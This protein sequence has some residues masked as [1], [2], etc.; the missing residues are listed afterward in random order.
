MTSSTKWTVAIFAVVAMFGAGMLWGGNVASELNP[1]NIL[2]SFDGLPEGDIGTATS[3]QLTLPEA[4]QGASGVP[5]PLPQAS[6]NN[7]LLNPGGGNV[8]I[9]TMDPKHLLHLKSDFSKLRIETNSD[10]AWTTIQLHRSRAGPPEVE[11]DDILGVVLARGSDGTKAQTAAVIVFLVDGGPGPGDM[12]GR[13]EFKTTLDGSIDTVTRMVIKNTGNVGIGTINPGHPLEMGSGA[14]VTA[15]GV[16]TDASSRL[17]KENIRDLT[18]EEA[19]AALRELTPTRFNY[20]VDKEEEHVGFIAEDV[21]ELVANK[22]RNGL[23]PMDI[24]AV[25]TKVVQGQEKKLAQL[26]AQLEQQMVGAEA[27][28]AHS[29]TR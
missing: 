13:I 16:W 2:A 5:K 8:G 14:H 25:L 9:G 20:K 17:F 22:D 18:L 19:M 26:Q 10:T 3:G 23:S 6:G 4:G 15:G 11:I 29:P 7:L 28:N 1:R 21:P 24:V 12:P 27:D